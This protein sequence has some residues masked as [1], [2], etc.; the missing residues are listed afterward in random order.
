MIDEIA[1]ANKIDPLAF[2]LDLLR[3]TPRAVNVLKIVAE[4]AD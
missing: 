2:R 4:M 3:N 1:F